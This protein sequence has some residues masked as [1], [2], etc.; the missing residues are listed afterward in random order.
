[1]LEPLEAQVLFYEDFENTDVS[2]SWEQPEGPKPW[3]TLSEKSAFSGTRGVNITNGES[4]MARRNLMWPVASSACTAGVY[5]AFRCRFN[6]PGLGDTAGALER[7]PL[8]HWE[9]TAGNSKFS[10]PTLLVV[11]NSQG[12]PCFR[13]LSRNHKSAEPVTTGDTPLTTVTPDTWYSLGIYVRLNGAA[14]I[15]SL[16]ING[17]CAGAANIALE[18]AP[19]FLNYISFGFNRKSSLPLNSVDIDDIILTR[20]R[21]D[22]FLPYRV[23]RRPAAFEYVGSPPVKF[24]IQPDAIPEGSRSILVHILQDHAC[25]AQSVCAI[26]S[27]VTFDNVLAPH[28]PYTYCL[29]FQGGECRFPEQRGGPFMIAEHAEEEET[30]SFGAGT[31]RFVLPHANAGRVMAGD[32]LL[33]EL[34][35]EPQK[36]GTCFIDLNIGSVK[37]SESRHERFGVY[38][39]GKNLVFSL[40]KQDLV[41]GKYQEGTNQLKAVSLVDTGSEYP[42][43]FIDAGGYSFDQRKGNA[44]FPFVITR[45]MEPGIWTIRAYLVNEHTGLRLSFNSLFFTVGRPLFSATHVLLVLFCVCGAIVIRVLLRR[46]QRKNEPPSSSW[47]SVADSIEELIIQTYRDTNLSNNT[48]AQHVNLSTPKVT[49]IYQRVK[50]KTPVQ[51]IREIRLEKAGLLLKTTMKSVS[52]IAYEAGFSDPVVF[53]RNFKK[54]KGLTPGQYR[55]KKSD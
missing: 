5:L 23:V 38:D 36:D 35:F 15:D 37:F 51:H 17:Q 55:D 42:F 32:T 31:I 9:I 24:E 22:P 7:F 33:V 46:R 13:M 43:N 16:F 26:D 20:T 27:L 12:N 11:Q 25:I 44:R 52:E 34:S 21:T 40:C 2:L 54:H 6:A 48:I 39:P 49:E 50:G 4:H 18:Q 3:L 47:L 30:R 53:Q 41:Y 19:L 29:I 8:V 28:I 1:M 14:L 45:D 10:N